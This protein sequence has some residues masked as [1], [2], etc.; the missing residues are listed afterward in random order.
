[1]R[2]KIKYLV[3]ALG[4]GISGLGGGIAVPGFMNDNTVQGILGIL[5]WLVGLALAG[6]AQEFISPDKHIYIKKD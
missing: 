4:I 6:Y 1:M 3:Y 5:V 2:L